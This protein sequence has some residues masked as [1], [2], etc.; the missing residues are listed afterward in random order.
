MSKQEAYREFMRQ[1]KPLLIAVALW[2]LTINLIHLQ[3]IRDEVQHFFVSFILESSV[4]FGKMLFLP[5]SSPA[6]PY[7]TVS[8]YTMEVIMECTAYNFYIFVIYLSLL[9]PV[10]WKNRII[11]LL[12]FLAAI[13]VINN[14]RFIVMGYIGKHNPEL[15][16]YIHDY[17]W[18]ILFGFLV[19]LIWM[20]RYQPAMDKLKQE[21]DA[22][23]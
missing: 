12:V 21:K 19:F 8:G 9:S 13:F 11:T 14:L 2:L 1:F 4:L 10:S 18:N 6:F 16:D 17:L 22:D 23:H 7:I 3:F 20:W 15:F 5:V